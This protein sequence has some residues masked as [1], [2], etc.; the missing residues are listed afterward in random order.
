MIAADEYTEKFMEEN[1]D[2][3]PEA[4]IN[5]ILTKI[6]KGAD[7][8]TSL[9]EYVVELIRKLDKNGDGVISFEEFTA[10]LKSMNIFITNHEEHEL[11]RIFDHNKD[12]KISME[13]FYNT[14]ANHC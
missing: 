6:K 5:Y 9:Q 12:G 1:P 4:D 2:L 11:M 14:L 3:Y 8:Y 13:E 10:G 7:K